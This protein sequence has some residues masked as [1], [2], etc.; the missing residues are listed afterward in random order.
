MQP[1]SAAIGVA[2]DGA[3][4]PALEVEVG[5]R[6]LD[7]LEVE[8][9]ERLDPLDRRRDAPVHVRVDPDLDV[10]PDAVADR[11]KRIVVLPEVAADLQLQFA[12]AGLDELRRLLRVRLRGVD[13]QVADQR[14]LLA[15]VAAEQLRD[16]K[17]R[18]PCP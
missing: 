5:H 16:G 9:L 18:A 12:V 17:P 8:P 6:L 3:R 4:R 1:S 11:R 15:A 7:V 13:E 2:T 10:S 14:D